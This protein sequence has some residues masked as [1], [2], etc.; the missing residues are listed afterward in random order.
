MSRVVVGTPLAERLERYSTPEPNSGCQL[1][2]A[3]TDVNGY[4]QL[5][6]GLPGARRRVHKA[7]RLS[8]MVHRGPIPSGL[9]VCHKCDVRACINPGHL[10]LGTNADNM[11]DMVAKGRHRQ[12]D[13]RGEK[14]G[15]THLS[16][17]QV[18]EIRADARTYRQIGEDFGISPASVCRI[19]CGDTWQHI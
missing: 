17:S 15:G 10:F 5:N 1:W 13:Y 6:V 14:H 12:G 19:K 11:A 16:N 9:F 18:R 7:H 8:W 2:C 3:S 4:G